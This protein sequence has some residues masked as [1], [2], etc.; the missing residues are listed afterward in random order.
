MAAKNFREAF[1]SLVPAF[2]L[3]GDGGKILH[4]LAL[5]KD[6]ALEKARLGL[7][8]RFPRRAGP[9]AL[10]LIG[11]DRQLLR[12]RS[13]ADA[14]YAERLTQWRTGYHSHRARGTA[15]ALL[16]QICEYVGGARCWTF[17]MHRVVFIRGGAAPGDPDFLVYD[18]DVESTA[19][20]FQPTFE[21]GTIDPNNWA[22]FFVTLNANPQLPWL[23]AAP[24]YGDAD[25]WGG[26]VGTLGYSIG[27]VGW[28]PTDTLAIRKLTRGR[29][30]WRPAG[31]L[32]EWLII[33]LT[34]WEAG[35]DI[36]PAEDWTH[37]SINDAGTQTPTR[38]TNARYISLSPHVNNAYAGDPDSFC[39]D[40]TMAGGGTYAGD[41][42]SF[43]TSV[44]LADGS[45]YAGD[46]ASFPLTVQLPDDGD[47][48]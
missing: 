33:Q 24:D 46:P 18:R 36:Q 31:T 41:P 40:S 44:V 32:P 4:S 26:A 6:I 1:W 14:D 27:M 2:L 42:D 39:S 7:E 20:D 34:D 35:N 21:W 28:T 30:P 3:E 45:T 8:A 19:D 37:W 16:H 17:D 22:R 48:T 12:G 10:A 23:L 29:R 38:S 11:A 15:W 9:S 5:L 13:E 43:P 25:L 47:Q